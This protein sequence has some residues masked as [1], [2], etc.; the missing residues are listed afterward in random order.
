MYNK[1]INSYCD[2]CVCNSCENQTQNGCKDSLD[3][4]DDCKRTLYGCYK[5]KRRSINNEQK[6]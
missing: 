4:C 1:H 6:N 5:Y 3:M 2:I